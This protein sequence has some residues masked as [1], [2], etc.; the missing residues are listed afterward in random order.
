MSFTSAPKLFSASPPTHSPSSQMRVTLSATT[1][2]FFSLG[3]P[4]TSERRGQRSVVL[5][6]SAARQFLRH[7]R[8]QFSDL[9]LR[10]RLHW[11]RSAA[12]RAREKLAEKR[13]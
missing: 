5:T 7:R 10:A 4:F 2:D 12:S 6:D 3:V 8:T 9:P 1:L 11:K 13:S